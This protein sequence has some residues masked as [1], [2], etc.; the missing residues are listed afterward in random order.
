M[1]EADH[2]AGIGGTARPGLYA[3]QEAAALMGGS[4]DARSSSGA[5][6]FSLTVAVRV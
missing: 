4:L 3:A 2:T 1:F 6:R 5:T